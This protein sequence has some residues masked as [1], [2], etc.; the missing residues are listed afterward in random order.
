M[1]DWEATLE[2]GSIDTI[3]EITFREDSISVKLYDAQS[4]LVHIGKHLGL[5]NRVQVE[6]WQDKVI[7]LLK[8]GSVTPDDVRNEL[9]DDLATELFKSAGI[10]AITVSETSSQS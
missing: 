4:A 1:L 2:N 3:K 9:G 10:P 5:F 8:E 6:T 7:E